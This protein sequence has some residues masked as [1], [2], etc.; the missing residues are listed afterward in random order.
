MP[1]GSLK[2]NKIE[3]TEK[4]GSQKPRARFQLGGRRGR[5]PGEDVYQEQREEGLLLQPRSQVSGADNP[6]HHLD[7][8]GEVRAA[9]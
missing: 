5:G 3:N 6:W 9:K 1:P 8:A 4:E 2:A 7:G